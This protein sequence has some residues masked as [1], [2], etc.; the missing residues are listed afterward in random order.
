MS[1][2]RPRPARPSS[3]RPT[4]VRV[5][6]PKA[7]AARE[8]PHPTRRWEHSDGRV[9]QVEVIGRALTGGSLVGAELLLL[10][11]RPAHDDGVEPDVDEGSEEGALESLVAAVSLES[12]SDHQLEEHF[13]RARRWE[14]EPDDEKSFFEGTRR[15]R[16]GRS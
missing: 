1:P 4:P 6:A 2:D 5:G 11:F 13:A 12:L 10:S 8:P 15:G 16:R 9:F 7:E 3:A 14:P